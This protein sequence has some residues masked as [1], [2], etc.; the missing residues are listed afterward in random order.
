MTDRQTDRQTDKEREGEK[1]CAKPIETGYKYTSYCFR[2]RGKVGGKWGNGG[3]LRLL[4]SINAKN[5]VN[6][7]WEYRVDF[8]VLRREKQR[9]RKKP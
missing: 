5:E 3:K 8:G 2:N 7:R 4:G 9:E 1:K 6:K